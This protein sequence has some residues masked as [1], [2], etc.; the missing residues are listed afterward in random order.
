MVDTEITAKVEALKEI[1]NAIKSLETQ[2]AE[3]EADIKAEMEARNTEELHAGLF[4]V[5][6]KKVISHRFDSKAFKETHE[7]LYSQYL[8]EVETMRFTIA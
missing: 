1:N 6:W 7:K 8:K 4:R 3:I 5:L 2:A